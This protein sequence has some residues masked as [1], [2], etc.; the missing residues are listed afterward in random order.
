MIIK[1][2]ECPKCEQKIGV[3]K[4]HLGEE[5]DCPRCGVTLAVAVI[6]VYDPKA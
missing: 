3:D 5:V 2:I 4:L 1:Q 6:V